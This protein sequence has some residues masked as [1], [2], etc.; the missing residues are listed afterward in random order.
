MI[1]RKFIAEKMREREVEEYIATE[2]GRD[3]YS[4]LQIKRTPLGE[5][6]TIYTSKPGFIVG[7]KGE[8]IKKMTLILKTKFGMENPQVEVAEFERPEQDAKSMA[9]YIAGSLERF[10]SNRF[11]SVGYRVLQR[12]MDAGAMGAEIVISGRGVPSSRAK[13]WRFYAG[14]LKKSGD[15]AETQVRKAVTSANLKSGTV[16]I[17]VSIMPADVLLPDRIIFPTAEEKK[18][19]PVEEVKEEDKKAEEAVEV[20]KENAEKPKKKAPAKKGDKKP[21]KKPE[22]KKAEKKT[23]EKKEAVKEEKKEEK[24]EAVKEEESKPEEKPKEEKK[25]EHKKAEKKEDKEEP[26]QE[27]KKEQAPLEE[28]KE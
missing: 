27:D 23:E 14:Y 17:K 19:E 28:K 8:T 11:K 1:E 6:I 22:H 16:G 3:K 26:K 13:H 24:K 18:E 9:D 12:I 21:R 4:F 5:K 25:E 10:G 2:I 15:I 7:R 20:L